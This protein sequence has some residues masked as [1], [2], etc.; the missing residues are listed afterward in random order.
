VLAFDRLR[1]DGED[2]ERAVDR[3]LALYKGDFLPGDRDATWS[4]RARL[5]LRTQFIRRVVRVGRELESAGVPRE[6]IRLY[7]RVACKPTIWP[8][9][10]TTG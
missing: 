3:L 5:R 2:P 9:S 10:S 1:V 6:A 4:V 7:E 8:K